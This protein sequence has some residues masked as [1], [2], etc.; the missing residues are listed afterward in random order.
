MVGYA[1]RIFS[2]AVEEPAENNRKVTIPEQMDFNLILM[3]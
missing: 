1:S 2:T 3:G